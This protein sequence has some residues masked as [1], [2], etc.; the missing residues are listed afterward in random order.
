MGDRMAQA[1]KKLATDWQGKKPPTKGQKAFIKVVRALP[2][3]G[4]LKK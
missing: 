1:A 4:K 2:D 3:K